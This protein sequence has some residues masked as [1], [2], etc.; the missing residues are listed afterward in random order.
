MQR[1]GFGIAE[2][3]YQTGGLAVLRA[4]GAEDVG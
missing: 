1:H 3:Q 2:R 4:D